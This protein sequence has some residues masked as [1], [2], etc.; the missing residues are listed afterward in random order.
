MVS[1]RTCVRRIAL[2]STFVISDFGSR[3]GQRGDDGS[4]AK[5]SPFAKSV[6]EGLP[7]RQLRPR[8]NRKL[9]ISPAAAVDRKPRARRWNRAIVYFVYKTR[10]YRLNCALLRLCWR[11]RS[12]LQPGVLGSPANDAFRRL[13]DR[14]GPISQIDTESHHCDCGPF[15]TV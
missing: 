4:N 12:A 7:L 11:P 14:S 6:G 10:D 3:G 15:S 9:V 8:S 13:P 2:R 1:A 5:P